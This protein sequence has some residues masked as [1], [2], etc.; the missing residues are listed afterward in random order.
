MH[1]L[2]FSFQVRFDNVCTHLPTHSIDTHIVDLNSAYMEK[3]SEPIQKL[4]P[5]IRGFT[6][7]IQ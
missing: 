5:T 7:R 4:I 3:T 6:K 2:N 1:I